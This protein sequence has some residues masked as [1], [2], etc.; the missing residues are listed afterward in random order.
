MFVCTSD[1]LALFADAFVRDATLDA[2]V[3]SYDETPACP[4][5]ISQY[6]NLFHYYVHQNSCGEIQTFWSGC[7]AVKRDVF[8]AI[9]GFEERYQRPSAED[10]ELGIR[11]TAAKRSHYPR[12]EH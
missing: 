8:L 5:F 12:R 10:I 11:M 9:G 7:G 2:I 1:T 6:K 3:G 4:N